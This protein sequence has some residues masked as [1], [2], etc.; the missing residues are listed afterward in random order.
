MAPEVVRPDHATAAARCTFNGGDHR[1]TVQIANGPIDR[2][3]SIW[4]VRLR[5][6]GMGEGV[7]DRGPHDWNPT[8]QGARHFESARVQLGD[9][10]KPRGS[11]RSLVCAGGIVKPRF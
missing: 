6:E 1:G 9:W 8:A 4:I 3:R 5:N 7:R 10:T 11:S 2:S